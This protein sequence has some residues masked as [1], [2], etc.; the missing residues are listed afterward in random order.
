[1]RLWQADRRAEALQVGLIDYLIEGDLAA[2]AAAF[3]RGVTERAGLHPKTRERHDKLGSAESNATLF[4]AG[5]ETARKTRRNLD[6]G[7]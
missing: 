2:G 3:A 7:T 5:R 1:M 4:A 6:G